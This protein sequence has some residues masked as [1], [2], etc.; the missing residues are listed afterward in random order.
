[1]KASPEIVEVM[2]EGILPTEQI[3]NQT[4]IFIPVRPA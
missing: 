1:M 4:C 2:I 3:Q